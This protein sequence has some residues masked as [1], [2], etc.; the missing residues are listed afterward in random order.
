MHYSVSVAII[1]LIDGVLRTIYYGLKVGINGDNLTSFDNQTTIGLSLKF[2]SI[3]MR[4]VLIY[5]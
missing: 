3:G 1:L 2:I 5:V 4:V